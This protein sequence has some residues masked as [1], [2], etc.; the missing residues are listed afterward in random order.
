MLAGLITLAHAVDD[1]PAPAASPHDVAVDAAPTSVVSAAKLTS[2]LAQ[3]PDPDE[4]GALRRALERY[5]NRQIA[6]GDQEAANLRHP[7]ARLA[8]EWAAVRSGMPEI[9]FSRVLRFIDNHPDWPALP[10]L[11]RRAEEAISAQRPGADVTLAY[12]ARHAPVTG[13]GRVAQAIGLEATGRPAEALAAIARVWRDDTLS[14]ELETRVLAAFGD[15][16]TVRDHRNRMEM[17]LFRGAS[18]AALRSA[19]RAGPDHVRLAQARI[20]LNRK[21]AS[22]KAAIAAVP[23]SLHKDTSYIFARAQMLRRDR[24]AEAAARLI[25]GLTRDPDILIDGDEWW[26]ER[27]LIA[28]QLLDTG[29]AELAY[30]VSAGHGAEK[31]SSRIEAEWH[32]GW[33]ALRFLSDPQRALTHFQR[34][35]PLATTPTSIARAAYWEAR[36]LEALGDLNAALARYDHAASQHTAYYGQL[37]RARLGRKD[38]ALRE[39]E[40]ATNG[41]HPALEALDVILLAGHTA[42]ARV[43]AMDIARHSADPSVMARLATAAQRL[44][45]ARVMVNIGKLGLQRG[46]PFDRIAFPLGAMPDFAMPNHRVER[47]LSFAITRQESAF[48]PHAVSH[49]GARGLMQLMP[50]TARETARRFGLPYDL[51][52]LT[53]DPAYNATLGSAHLADLLRDWRGSYILTFAAYNAGSGNVRDWIEAFG[54]PRSADVDPIDWVERIPFSETRNYVQRIFENLQIYRVALE[55]Q[56]NLLL[57]ADLRRG[58]RTQAFSGEGGDLIALAEP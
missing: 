6:E 53:V 39:M 40:P 44:S 10:S 28:R 3:A 36:A 55:R 45:D 50:P 16:L 33:I 9:R 46:L 51:G 17:L 23:A 37:A 11:L 43:L 32:A 26:V 35:G 38:L 1:V 4:L 58:T 19:R 54:D 5:E 52:R 47:A 27:R 21:S 20:A 24:N 30:Q 12:F 15:R 56:P 42:S 57:L 41:R 49:A 8:A 29:R 14:S 2:A 48:D 13:A 18:E 25:A 31:A 7:A 22:A 34:I